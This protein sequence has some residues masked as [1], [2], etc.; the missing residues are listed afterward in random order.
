LSILI[1]IFTFNVY[2]GSESLLQTVVPLQKD[3]KINLGVGVPDLFS[4]NYFKTVSPKSKIGMG[5]GLLPPFV[6]GAL[7][8]V[9]A[10]NVLSDT[11]TV[12]VR[13]STF[14]VSS[15]ISYGYA[16]WENHRHF[17]LSLGLLLLNSK[18][19]AVLKN[20]DTQNSLSVSE[21]DVNL[22]QPYL[23]L[24]Y[25]QKLFTWDTFVLEGGLGVCLLSN[26][27]ILTNVSGSGSAYL[28]VA[29]EWREA[30]SDGVTEA[31]NNLVSVLN[32]W[33]N[34]PFILP[35]LYLQATW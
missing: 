35:S 10:D 3:S 25:Q 34:K 7:L 4:I 8:P 26:F 1:F 15:S 29:P 19:V 32:Q 14:L 27:S 23:N 17:L 24:R 9:P 33:K 21:I 20:Q 18:L 16:P 22:F 2:A 5:F 28:D 31:Q 11:Y 30:V 13:P 12:S 6:F